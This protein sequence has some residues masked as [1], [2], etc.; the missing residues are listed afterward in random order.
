MAN[1]T[2]IDSYNGNGLTLSAYVDS[3]LAQNH[4][5]GGVSGAPHKNF[6][7]T[8]SYT[9][10]TTG[11]V[12]DVNFGP[13]PPYP[14]LVIGNGAASNFIQALQGIGP[15]FDNDTGAFGQMPANGLPPTRPFFTADQIAPIAAWINGGCLNP[16]GT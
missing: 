10:F 2:V 3:I 6:W 13:N 8:L 7:K 4:E 15:L 12:P 11:N 1:A 14:I 5:A 16:G 9:E